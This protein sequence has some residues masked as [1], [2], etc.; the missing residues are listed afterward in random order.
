MASRVAGRGNEQKIGVEAHGRHARG[1]ALD[2]QA[3]GANAVVHDARAAE[4]RSEA[5]VVG[6][7][8]AVREK[9]ERHPA[10]SPPSV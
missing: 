8:I 1:Y 5:G 10:A 4:M 9:H 7:V 2:A 6:D 3:G